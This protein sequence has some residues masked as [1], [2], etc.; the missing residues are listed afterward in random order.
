MNKFSPSDN[1]KAF[2]TAL[3][4]FSTGVTIVTALG[5]DGPIGMTA[6]SFSSLSLTPP[7]LMWAPSKL[8][9]RHD[10]FIKADNFVVHVLA[11]EQKNMCDAFSKSK[12]CFEDFSYELNEFDVPVLENCLAVFECNRR[13]VHDA[14]DHSLIIGEVIQASEKAGNALVFSQGAFISVP[15]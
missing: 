7:L 1:D 11:F 4:R 6:N 13:A 8:S 12:D 15:Y 5:S 3:S 14:G 10:A 9:A 2:R